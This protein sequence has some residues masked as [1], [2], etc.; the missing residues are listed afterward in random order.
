MKIERWVL[1]RP[2]VRQLL[3]S[4]AMQQACREQAEAIAA[5]AGEG[6]AVDTFVGRNRVNASV[7]P[8]TIQA[9]FDNLR[10]NT[11]LKAM[12]GGA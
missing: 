1:N 3:Q 7:Y 5:R 9:K 8:E 10:H 2:G 6:Y 12:G 4:A 11:L